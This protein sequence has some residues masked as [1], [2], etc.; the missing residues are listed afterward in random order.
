MLTGLIGKK[1]AMGQDFTED[2]KVVPLT[3]VELGPCRVLQTKTE[4]SDGYRAVKLAFGQG[5]G[6]YN[7]KPTLGEAKKAKSDLAPEKITEIRGDFGDDIK[8]GQE[9]TLDQVF[10]EGD[11]VKATGTSKGRG[12]AGVMK[13]WGFHG[14][15]ATHGQSDRL[16]APGS[17][18]QGTDPGRVHKGKKMP[19]HFGVDRVTVKNLTVFK[20]DKENNRL[21]LTGAV[22]GARGGY[23]VVEKINSK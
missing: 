5:K 15:P 2:G 3:I 12:F 9:I 20:I 23:L 4:D 17:I 13:R 6:K 18:G 1:I 14:G 16:R 10:S 22:P 7:K 21:Y 11:R 8:V 19:G